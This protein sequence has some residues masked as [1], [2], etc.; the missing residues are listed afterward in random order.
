MSFENFV[1]TFEVRPEDHGASVVGV[2]RSV[3]EDAPP[4]AR[5]YRP[6]EVRGYV[7]PSESGV[8]LAISVAIDP[9]D[10]GRRR[11][12]LVGYRNDLEAAVAFLGSWA[13]RL[14]FPGHADPI[15]VVTGQEGAR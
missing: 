1:R 15:V 4:G 13:D 9:P 2:V 10:A 11:W 8:G 7:R 12:M 3:G 6:A 14:A 5:T